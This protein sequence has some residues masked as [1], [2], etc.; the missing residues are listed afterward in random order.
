MRPEQHFRKQVEERIKQK[1]DYRK[2]RHHI[3]RAMIVAEKYLV[4]FRQDPAENDKICQRISHENRPE[5][6][7]WFLEEMIENARRRF[8][9]PRQPANAHA[10]QCKYAR[11]HAGKQK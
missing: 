1:N 10:I 11:L 8:A 4:Q 7:F 2:Q 9:A 6:P 5:K 3:R